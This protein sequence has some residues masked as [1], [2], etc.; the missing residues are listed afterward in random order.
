MEKTS[1]ERQENNRGELIKGK[2]AEREVRERIQ[3]QG[4]ICLCGCLFGHA[5][6]TSKFSASLSFPS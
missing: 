3:S 5:C 1:R 4:F 6:Q 2:V